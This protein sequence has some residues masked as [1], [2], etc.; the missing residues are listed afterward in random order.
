[1]FTTVALSSLIVGCTTA[2]FIAYNAPNLQGLAFA[3]W[4]YSCITAYNH[5]YPSSLKPTREHLHCLLTAAAFWVLIYTPFID[6]ISSSLT[7]PCFSVLTLL[8]GLC[9][10]FF[11]FLACIY[12][13]P[14]FLEIWLI[15]Q[16]GF[17]QFCWQ[18]TQSKLGVECKG[19]GINGDE[20][21]EGWSLKLRTHYENNI[22]VSYKKLLWIY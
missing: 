9:P 21:P 13:Q 22:L 17:W 2:W 10:C 7:T 8:T 12:W 16:I 15:I 1:M 20:R 11:Y 3:T 6:G 18:A 14:A 4:V 5:F 19:S